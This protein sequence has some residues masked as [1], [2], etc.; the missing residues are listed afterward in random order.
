MEERF[1]IGETILGYKVDALLGSGG[2]GKVYRVSKTDLSGTSVRAL[3]HIAFPTQQ[4]YASVLRT[5]GDDHGKAQ[6]YFRE[7]LGGIVG[8]V[9]IFRHLSE[10][11]SA[12]IVRYYDSHINEYND[13]VTGQLRFDVFILMEYLTSFPDLL[14][15]HDFTLRDV[16]SLGLD[17][18][19]ALRVCHEN[20]VIHRDVKDDNIFVTEKGRFKLG[21]FGVSKKLDGRSRAESMKGTPAYI[22]PEVYMGRGAYTKS[23]DLYSLGM[24]L[25]HLLNHSRAPFLP[26]YPNAYSS[27]AEEAAF[28]ERMK[29]TVP[30]PPA[31]APEVLAKMLVKAVSGPRERYQDTD[32]FIKDLLAA[33]AA[34]PPGE[35]VHIVSRASAQQTA[36]SYAA[37]GQAG[38]QGQTNW[39]GQRDPTPFDATVADR[40]RGDMNRNLFGTANLSVQQDATG[41]GTQPVYRGGNTP[42]PK[43]GQTPGQT[44]GQ[45]P[46]P[47]S[48]RSYGQGDI[49]EGG[50][51]ERVPIIT[52]DNL[53]YLL[54]ALLPIGAILAV[55]LIFVVRPALSEKEST[56]A[57]V[58]QAASEE[59]SNQEPVT[60]AAGSDDGVS[61]SAG[62]GDGVSEPVAAPANI[63]YAG[64]N[65]PWIWTSSSVLAPSAYYGAESAGDWDWRTAWCEGVD[66][67]GAGE[68]LQL[69]TSS[70]RV[71]VVDNVV[72]V[73]GYRETEAKYLESN[74]PVEVTLEFSDGSS[75]NAHLSA[76]YSEADS[77]ALPE[78]KPTSYVRIYIRSVD[79]G[80]KWDDTCI[81]EAHVNATQADIDRMLPGAAAAQAASPETQA[82]P[83]VP[84]T[85]AENEILRIRKIWNADRAAITSKQYAVS[86]P[87]GGVVSYSSG[88]VVRMIEIS[89]SATDFGNYAR[90]YEFENGVL[91][92]AF[93]EG[94]DAHRLYF[95]DGQLF[96]WRYTPSSKDPDKGTNHDNEFGSSEFL[97]LESFALQEAYAW[98]N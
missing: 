26:P 43:A 84:F 32:G 16:F 71:A 65:E 7:A 9:K 47:A 87:A 81:A 37:P 49:S 36:A 59:V 85:N 78:P 45:A 93:L 92:F 83:R 30:P 74:R 54:L 53:K 88:G 10:D 90:T 4:Q 3:K 63:E 70:G 48:G 95:K 96:R 33:K 39:I 27:A 68:W 35:L 73:R 58:T 80:T 64:F 97:A 17:I 28:V 19:S 15:R 76:G 6:A 75:W 12:N 8:E 24:V 41:A 91:I 34:I 18:A 46:G 77:I 44:P 23:V 66:G 67:S 51:P 22:A 11:D 82:Q 38:L 62:E 55:I 50:R 20:G 60:A 61:G 79:A 2:F 1:L 25:Y 72:I 89:K 94:S 52:K 31:M 13:P 56:N 14:S 57:V 21:D 86:K 98:L 69:S 29:G 40:H 5:M 42:G